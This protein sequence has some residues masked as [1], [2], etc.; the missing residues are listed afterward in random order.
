MKR[1]RRKLIMDKSTLFKNIR[2]YLKR[3][4]EKMKE[5]W[6]TVRNFEKENYYLAYFILSVLI[7]TGLIGIILLYYLFSGA[8]YLVNLFLH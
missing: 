7:V 6:P 3:I 8:I 5:F 2:A 4:L 1:K